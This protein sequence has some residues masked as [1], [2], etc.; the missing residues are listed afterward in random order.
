MAMA[1]WL[2]QY[3]RSGCGT[4]TEQRKLKAKTVKPNA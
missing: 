3:G 1:N 2:L 4:G